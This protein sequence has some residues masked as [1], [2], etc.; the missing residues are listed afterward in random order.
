MVT[1]SPCTHSVS[2]IVISTHSLVFSIPVGILVALVATAIAFCAGGYQEIYFC[3][4]CLNSVLL[5][6]DTSGVILIVRSSKVGFGD[7][8]A[9]GSQIFKHKN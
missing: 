3:G 6:E 4:L 1:I 2:E 7:F 8:L 5:L 9:K